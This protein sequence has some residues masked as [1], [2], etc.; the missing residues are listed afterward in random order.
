[1]ERCRPE[2]SE[3]ITS[4]LPPRE[5]AIEHV[6]GVSEEEEKAFQEVF[7]HR[8]V[9]QAQ[10]EGETVMTRE[11]REVIEESLRN[12]PA[13]VARYGGRPLPLTAD[14]FHVVDLS[15]LPEAERQ[16]RQ[17]HSSDYDAIHQHAIIYR[18]DPAEVLP[19]LEILRRA[20]HEGLHFNA[21][22]S[23]QSQPA[24]DGQLA[25]R[26]YGLASYDAKHDRWSGLELNEAVEEELT[27]RYCREQIESSK[28]FEAAKKYSDSLLAFAPA[29]ER[30]SADDLV[31]VDLVE[32]EVEGD[33]FRF[34]LYG[35]TEGRQK[36][37][38]LL[39]GLVASDK[40]PFSDREEVFE[41]FARAS[42]THDLLTLARVVE[43]TYGRGSFRELMNGEDLTKE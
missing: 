20:A 39:D 25:E 18:N 40:N 21:F 8:F 43:D 7:R 27:I 14:Q 16:I 33:K 6:A 4:N 31:A 29:G 2:P 10:L 3:N 11:E 9:E 30:P 1:M 28:L 32:D 19:E 37:N 15:Q 36:L 5:Q 22:Q 12:L 41:I 34:Y 42:L 13:F 35:Y 26:R 17:Q 24:A 23:L 38:A